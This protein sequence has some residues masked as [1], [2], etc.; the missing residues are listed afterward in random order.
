MELDVRTPIPRGTTLVIGGKDVPIN[1]KY[2]R[3]PNFCYW[4]GLLDHVVSDCE[5]ALEAGGDLADFHFDDELRDFPPKRSSWHESRPIYGFN[6]RSDRSSTDNAG[7]QSFFSGKAGPQR[8][9]LSGGSQTVGSGRNSGSWLG[10]KVVV[11]RRTE[12]EQQPQLQVYYPASNSLPERQQQVN[13]I[14]LD[15]MGVK[16]GFS[17]LPSS[18]ELGQAVAVNHRPDL[19]QQP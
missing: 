3:L 19:E 13:T 12:P 4:C 14:P 17:D 6:S 9:D 10:Q 16:L 2:E 8:S 15:S 1:F 5:V 7:R 18:C 11:S